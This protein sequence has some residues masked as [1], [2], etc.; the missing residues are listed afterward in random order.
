MHFID[1]GSVPD[2]KK[3]ANDQT[4]NLNVRI[5]ITYYIEMRMLY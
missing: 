1:S 5:K 4:S 3:S 2:F